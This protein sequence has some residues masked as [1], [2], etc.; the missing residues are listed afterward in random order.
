[1]VRHAAATG[2]GKTQALDDL[3][4]RE[5]LF[6]EAIR[7]GLDV[8]ADVRDEVRRAMIRRLLSQEFEAVTTPDSIPER[9]LRAAFERG[10]Y[11][12]VHDELVRTRHLLLSFDA[13]KPK[14]RRGQVPTGPAPGE[15]WRWQLAEKF[16]GELR[17]A[18]PVNPTREQ[19]A[20][21][22]STPLPE[23]LEPPAGSGLA[24]GAPTQS[25]AKLTWE[26]LS[27]FPRQGSSIVE[28]F[29][30]AAHGLKRPGD[31][32]PPVRTQF[33]VHLIYLVERI[34]ARHSSYA[35]ALPELRTKLYPGYR[36]AEFLRFMERMQRSHRI[37]RN[38]APLTQP[39][40][41]AAAP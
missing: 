4:Q 36:R 28:P 17:A 7:R 2:L 8:R 33:G 16:L 38:D 22:A 14:S 34:P 31:V 32:S 30:A 20:Q 5:L 27:P 25:T 9:S 12:F 3:I 35:Q 24:T 26:D 6:Q 40:D 37:V 13:P 29:S 1:V 41:P 21:L 23:G 19:W 10:K 18:L 39:P 11:H 15:E